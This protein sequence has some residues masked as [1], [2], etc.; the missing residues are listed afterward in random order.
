MVEGVNL[1]LDA[2]G[3]RFYDG[4]IVEYH[5]R[6]LILFE[7][8]GGRWKGCS[9]S[10]LQLLVDW[11]RMS[12]MQVVTAMSCTWWLRVNR[13]SAMSALGGTILR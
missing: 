12:E 1:R 7:E 6:N 10:I 2:D 11:R 8:A 4:N 3:A 13:T 5:M 9:N